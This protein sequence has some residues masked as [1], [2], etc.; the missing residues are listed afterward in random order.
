MSEWDFLVEA[1]IDAIRVDSEKKEVRIDVTCMWQD[2]KR[3]QIIATG[4]DDFVVNEMRLSNIIDRVTR[5]GTS[6]V[7]EEESETAKRLFF[8]MRGREPDSNDL[9]WPVLIENLD[10]IRDGTLGLMEIEPVY[11][12][13]VI[14]LAQNFQ[15]ESI[16]DQNS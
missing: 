13:T 2:E 11:G 8:M 1:T 3:K 4:V 12:A 9:K 5:F 16:D 15:L 14:V 10:R 7:A 6:G